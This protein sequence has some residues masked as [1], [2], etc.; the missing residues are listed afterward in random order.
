MARFK[1]AN[2]RRSTSAT[3]YFCGRW[4]ATLYRDITEKHRARVCEF[5]VEEGRVIKG[6]DGV[7]VMNPEPL[8]DPEGSPESGTRS[9]SADEG[10]SDPA[11]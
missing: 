10:A 9:S 5:C 7:Y 1:T 11:A 6:E 2:T 3:C 4:P 8:A